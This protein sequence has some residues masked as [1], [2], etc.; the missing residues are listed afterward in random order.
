MENV[1]NR[2]LRPYYVQILDAYMHIFKIIWHFFGHLVQQ[3]KISLVLGILEIALLKLK[4]SKQ[5][6]SSFSSFFLQSEGQF[7]RPLDIE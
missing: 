3:A 5:R 7:P 6:V 1:P 2:Y 4:A